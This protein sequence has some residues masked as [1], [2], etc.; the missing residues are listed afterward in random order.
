MSISTDANCRGPFE[1]ALRHTSEPCLHD[2]HQLPLMDGR[3]GR[4]PG[5]VFTK[6]SYSATRLAEI[7]R[8]HQEPGM[9]S[10][11][12]YQSAPLRSFDHGSIS[13]H[14]VLKTTMRRA[15]IPG[16]CLRPMPASTQVIGI[17]SSGTRNRSCTTPTRLIGPF[18]GSSGSRYGD[19]DEDESTWSAI[20]D[21]EE[22][23]RAS[24]YRY[25]RPGRHGNTYRFQ[26]W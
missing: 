9:F 25:A 20:Y 12:P 16:A 18:C 23:S 14:F 13:E 6:N 10:A 7:S 26:I 11:R 1:T 4:R 3:S 24:D 5:H 22:C 15:A 17:S 19:E 2:I 21:Y 8:P